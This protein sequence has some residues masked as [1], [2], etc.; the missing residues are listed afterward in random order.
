[1]LD[2]LLMHTLCDYLYE[3]SDVLPQLP[4]SPTLLVSDENFGCGVDAA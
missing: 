1:M 2:D 3:V 4:P